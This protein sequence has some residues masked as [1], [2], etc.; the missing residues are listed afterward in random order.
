MALHRPTGHCA[1]ST[2]I[3]G[4]PPSPGPVLGRR[5]ADESESESE[6]EN[7]H[8]CKG[9]YENENENQNENPRC[10]SILYARLRTRTEAGEEVRN[11][12]EE[13]TAALGLR[14]VSLLG[15]L[16]LIM[17][18]RV[19]APRWWHDGYYRSRS[20]SSTV[21]LPPRALGTNAPGGA[22]TYSGPGGYVTP[23]AVSSAR[24]A[25]AITGENV[26]LTENVLLGIPAE[27]LQLY[28]Y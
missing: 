21:T 15:I 2:S 6:I 23:P 10:T 8:L 1:G 13:P 19:P 20:R 5:F 22:R 16:A 14:D 11:S 25:S 17:I 12:R 18:S 9:A 28:S 4:R 27:R 7:F 3:S 26:T 24:R